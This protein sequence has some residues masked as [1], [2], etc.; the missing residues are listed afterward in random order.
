MPLTTIR[1]FLPH[2]VIPAIAI[3]AHMGLAGEADRSGNKPADVSISVPDGCV[4]LSLGTH[5]VICAPSDQMYASDVF[6]EFDRRRAAAKSPDELIAR[7]SA[8]RELLATAVLKDLPSLTPSAVDLF[9][10]TEVVPALQAAASPKSPQVFLL[11]T[12]K[13]LKQA[14]TAG[15]STPSIQYHALADKVRVV[16]EGFAI[17]SDYPK[18]TYVEIKPTDADYSSRVTSSADAVMEAESRDFA[19][20][21][22]KAIAGA[23]TRF[24]TFIGRAL[25]PNLVASADKE[26]FGIGLRGALAARYVALFHGDPPRRFVDAMVTPVGN[27]VVRAAELDLLQPYPLTSLKPA[28]VPVHQDARRRKS[29][30]IMHHWLDRIEAGQVATTLQALDRLAP[31]DGLTLA[32]IVHDTSGVELTALLRPAR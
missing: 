1:L 32:R 21:D 24:E 29:V 9:F 3:F 6:A 8:K 14:L 4:K 19:L 15:W 31:E 23:M 30:A 7:F 17:V 12:E 25:P 13:T 28:Y 2:C 10:D 5:A 20:R 16:D 26:W 18:Y 22:A 11:M 27:V